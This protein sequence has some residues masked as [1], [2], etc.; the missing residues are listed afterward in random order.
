MTSN[1]VDAFLNAYSSDK[2][3]EQLRQL[4]AYLHWNE[5]D[6]SQGLE[7]AAETI[8]AFGAMLRKDELERWIGKT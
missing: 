2:D 8:N 5:V 6:R 7:A 1:E 3:K 4:V